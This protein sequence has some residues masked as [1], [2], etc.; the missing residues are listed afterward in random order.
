ML[1]EEIQKK[2]RRQFGVMST[3]CSDLSLVW[4]E[5]MG[6]TEGDSQALGVLEEK[7]NKNKK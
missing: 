1:A 2:K 3:G 7:T 5:W 4:K 6:E